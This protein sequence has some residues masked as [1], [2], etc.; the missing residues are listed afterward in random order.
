MRMYWPVAL[1]QLF[2]TLGWTVYVIFLP[3]LLKQAGIEPAWLPWILIVDQLLFAA[4]DVAT[5]LW[6]DRSERILARAG[7]WV[8]VLVLAACAI[9]TLLPLIAQSVPSWVFLLAIFAWV[10]CSSVLRVPP[11]VLLARYATPQ[12]PSSFSYPVAAYL[13]GLG[14]AGAVAPYLTVI[15]KNRDPMLPFILASLA[16][17]LATLALRHQF[18]ALKPI[19]VPPVQTDVAGKFRTAWPLL[20]AVGMLAFG[21]QIHAAVNSSKL[22]ARVAPD[23]PLDWLMPLFWAGFSLAMFPVSTWLARAGTNIG[24]YAVASRILWIAGVAGGTA[25]IFCA[26]VP[27]LPL[28]VSLQVIA[29]AAWGA[30]FLAAIACAAELGRSGREGGW[31]GSML[32]LIA[33]ATAGRIALVLFMSPRGAISVS[34]MLWLTGALWLMGVGALALSSKLRMSNG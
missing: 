25:L 5:G 19:A 30:V 21:I 18:S 6:L 10:I 13:F 29:G 1:V 14:V 17:V 32:A 8:L 9:F 15:L 20:V 24:S 27:Q 23:V 7:D 31:V 4:A 3:G 11:L 33:L 12:Q 2:F 16:L 28:L 26:T 22:F 34:Q